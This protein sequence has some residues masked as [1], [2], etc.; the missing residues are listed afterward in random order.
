MNIF[1]YRNIPLTPAYRWLVL[2]L[3]CLFLLSIV[4]ILST[5]IAGGSLDDAART[6]YFETYYSAMVREVV[7]GHPLMGNPYFYEHREGIAPAFFLPFWLTALPQVLGLSQSL[8]VLFNFSFWT[9]IFGLILYA[10]FV[11]LGLSPPWSAIGTLLCYLQ[12]YVYLIRPVSMQAVYPFFL[13]F[14]FAFVVWWR[15]QNRYTNSFLGLAT[16]LTFYDYTYLWQVITIFLGLSFFSM[17]IMRDWPRVR[18]ALVIG[19]G[20]AI[21][22]VPMVFLTLAQIHDPY[23]WETMMRIGLGRTHLPAGEAVWGGMRMFVFAI[24]ALSIWK[25]VVQKEVHTAR[26]LFVLQY[27]LLGVAIE[28][29]SVSN[30]IT[31][32]DLETASHMAR[33][34]AMWLAIGIVAALYVVWDARARLRSLHPIQNIILC[35]LFAFVGAS[36]LA[37]A[38][39]PLDFFKFNEVRMRITTEQAYMPALQWIDQHESTPQVIWTDPRAM[40]LQLIPIYTKHYVLFAPSGLLQLGSSDEMQERYLTAGSLSHLTLDQISADIW[41]YNGVGFAID[42]P[43]TINR[44][45][46][47]C[48]ALHL[49]ALGFSCG[50]LTD[51]QTLNATLYE[52]MYRRYNED[53]KPN[54]QEEL[55]KFHVSYIMKDSLKDTA[56][57][58]EQLKN[59]E[60][61]HSDGRILIYK[62]FQAR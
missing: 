4:P 38:T 62:V 60:L 45:V 51:A 48:R 11:R 5:C 58:P 40:L 24:L 21:L 35:A 41:A 2:C 3:G 23:Y 6:F 16:A 20:V 34:V 12:V 1:G 9:L 53:I 8:S 17:L 54:L 27:M 59:A 22:I 10:F 13:L 46:K 14:M 7:N 50:N 31:G 36:A 26:T 42:I 44:K 19:L 37:Y 33:F 56:F 29:A 39:S 47:V 61:V 57:H 28:I 30:V 55:K 25:W 32:M 18:A 15:K 52:R 43:N 49:S